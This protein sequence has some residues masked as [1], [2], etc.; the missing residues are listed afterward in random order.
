MPSS[1][2]LNLKSLLLLLS[3]FTAFTSGYAPLEPADDKAYLAIWLDTNP[4]AGDDSPAKTVERTGLSFPIYHFAFD[5]PSDNDYRVKLEDGETHGVKEL[6]QETK[7]NAGVYMTL[8]PKFGFEKVDDEAIS[9]LVKVIKDFH[10]SNISVFIRYAPEMNGDFNEYGQRPTEFKESW[11]KLYKALHEQTGGNNSTSTSPSSNSTS[12]SPTSTPSLRRRMVRRQANNSTVIGTPG[13]STTTPANGGNSTSGTSTPI[14]QRNPNVAL[15]WSPN[16]GYSPIANITDE[17][18]PD[19]KLLDTNNDTKITAEDDY[20]AAYWPGDE[21]VD[22]VGLSI[23]AFGYDSDVLDNIH[24]EPGYVESI[25]DNS[26]QSFYETYAMGKGKPMSISETGAP[27]AVDVKAAEGVTEL[28]R[29]K[30]FWGQF[31]TNDTFHSTYPLIK[32]YCQFEF[33]KTEDV[34]PRA[35]VRDYRVTFN[36]TILEAF[37]EDL[38]VGNNTL[39]SSNTTS[40]RFVWATNNTDEF[41]APFLEGNGISGGNGTNFGNGTVA[42]AGR[43][44]GTGGTGTVNNTLTPGGTRNVS[45]FGAAS[46]SY[47]SAAWLPFVSTLASLFL[48]FAAFL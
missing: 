35:H 38:Q 17:N 15:V 42:P 19:F 6:V 25:I 44:N 16:M 2:R 18:S 11:I 5:I 21:Y 46:P 29:K 37:K 47:G 48:V 31:I 45:A 30:E 9:Q 43:R 7:T 12:T 8:Y 34:P 23:Y 4:Q 27:W 10:D 1:S 39:Q 22:W 28:G 13:N 14:A 36:N 3:S 41:I 24:V 32:L 26:T 33:N 40:G 20:Y